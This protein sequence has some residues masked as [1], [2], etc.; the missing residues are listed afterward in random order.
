MF[1]AITVVCGMITL[2]RARGYLMLCGE[3]TL[4]GYCILKDCSCDY[5]MFMLAN[6]SILVGLA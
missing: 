5:L 3:I 4:C 2:R 1:G 6:L